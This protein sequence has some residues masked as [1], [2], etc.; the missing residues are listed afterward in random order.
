MSKPEVVRHLNH[1]VSSLWDVVIPFKES[2][3]QA[4]EEE[5]ALR[6]ALAVVQRYEKLALQTIGTSPKNADWTMVQMAVK[7]DKVVVTVQQG[8]CG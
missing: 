4:K 1:P 6:A 2:E 3:D 8:M 5:D 7:N